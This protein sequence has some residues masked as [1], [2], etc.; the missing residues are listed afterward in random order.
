LRFLI[1]LATILVYSIANKKVFILLKY[2]LNKLSYI[3]V[4][5]TIFFKL[6]V[7]SMFLLVKIIKVIFI[8][9]NLLVAKTAILAIILNFLFI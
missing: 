9:N 4:M 8:N 6:K 5:L 1:I 2:I 7:L 3:I